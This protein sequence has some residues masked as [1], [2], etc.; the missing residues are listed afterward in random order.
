M[1]LDFYIMSVKGDYD[2]TIES[3]NITH[4]LTH[5]ADACGLYDVLW[6]PEEHGYETTDDIADI[7]LD[8]LNTLLESPERMRKYNAPNGWGMYEDFC[9]FVLDVY[10][11]VRSN[12][13][14][15]IHASR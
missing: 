13:G 4:N 12:K 6:R 10:I 15:F 11:A 1:S 9:R 2:S 5:M 3:F 7:L 14:A 8:G